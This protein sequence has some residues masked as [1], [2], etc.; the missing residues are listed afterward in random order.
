LPAQEQQQNDA[1]DRQ[2]TAGILSTS[3]ECS[4]STGAFLIDTSMWEFAS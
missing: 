2:K 3:C 4:V 1:R